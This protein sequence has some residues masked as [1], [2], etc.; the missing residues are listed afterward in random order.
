MKRQL[1]AI[2]DINVTYWSKK[3]LRKS[4]LKNVRTQVTGNNTRQSATSEKLWTTPKI[5]LGQTESNV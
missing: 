2:S 4:L 3:D 5:T 1:S